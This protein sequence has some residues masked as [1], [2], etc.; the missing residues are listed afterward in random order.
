MGENSAVYIGEPAGLTHVFASARA[1]AEIVAKDDGDVWLFPGVSGVCGEEC[2]K[3][4][5]ASGLV[6]KSHVSPRAK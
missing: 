4:K 6:E 3:E 2:E 5:R 1:V